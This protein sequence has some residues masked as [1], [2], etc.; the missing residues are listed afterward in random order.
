MVSM[1]RKDRDVLRFLWLKDA[2]TT[3]ELIY[4]GCVRDPFQSVFA[5][6]N[7]TTPSQQYKSSHLQ[8]IK[9]LHAS[10]GV[11]DL[12]CGACLMVSMGRKDRDVLRFL[13]LEDSSMTQQDLKELIYPGCVRNPFQSVSAQHKN[14]SST[15]HPTLNSSRSYTRHSM[16]MTWPVEPP[17]KN[18]H[19]KHS[20]QPK[21]F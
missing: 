14:T 11:D 5:Q 1:G 6:R 12:A 2:C 16:S 7:N 13:W 9:E 19:T 3:Q 15:N 20:R 18:R 4:P 8:L 10:L 17:M 21:R